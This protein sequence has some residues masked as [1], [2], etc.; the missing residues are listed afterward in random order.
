[1]YTEE[2]DP[3]CIRGAIPPVYRERT[4]RPVYRES[5][6]HMYK[7]GDPTSIQEEGLLDNQNQVK[8]DLKRSDN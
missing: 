1:M 4:V 2:R 3:S 5:R 7:R 8:L 6:Y